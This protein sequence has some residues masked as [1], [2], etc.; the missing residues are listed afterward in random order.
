MLI[1]QNKY[2]GGAIR[3]NERLPVG[4][5][6]ACELIGSHGTPI[7]L[8][9]FSV[10]VRGKPKLLWVMESE[11]PEN[12]HCRNRNRLFLSSTSTRPDAEMTGTTER[13]GYGFWRL[14]GV[15]Y[16]LTK[17]SGNVSTPPCSGFRLR[18]CGLGDFVSSERARKEA[19]G[20]EGG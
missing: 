3:P 8:I 14:V 20:N 19:S 13:P 7:T 10:G 6:V 2:E 16:L 5:K 17:N 12:R 18:R 1:T 9:P 4:I 15:V 11:T